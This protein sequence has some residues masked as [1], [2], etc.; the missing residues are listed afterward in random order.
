ME[1]RTLNQLYYKG[2]F[3]FLML[4]FFFVVNPR[5]ARSEDLVNTLEKASEALQNGSFEE[6]KSLAGS[7]A[8]SKK[9]IDDVDRAQAWRIYGVALFFLAKYNEAETA[10]FEYLKRDPDATLD[11]NLVPKDAIA[12][13]QDVRN[14]YTKEIRKI[15]EKNKKTKI[16]PFLNLLPPVG[17]FQN[18]QSKKAWGI[19]GVEL[20]LIAIHI[21]SYFMLK[22]WCNSETGV[23]TSG[24]E[25]SPKDRFSDANLMNHVNIWSGVLFVGV[26]IYGIVDGFLNIPKKKKKG[27]LQGFLQ[28]HIHLDNETALVGVRLTL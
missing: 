27:I 7:V 1:I 22:S 23:C 17:Q 21:G 3:T 20:S 15:R 25:E 18:K 9:K 19:L 28:P 2:L 13:F 10:F 5:D 11:P 12:F 4:T 14:R 16:Y 26:Y 6:A 8:N 24:G